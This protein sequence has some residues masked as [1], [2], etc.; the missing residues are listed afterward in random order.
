MVAR[1]FLSFLTVLRDV[2][3][4]CLEGEFLKDETYKIVYIHMQI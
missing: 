3:H 2:D 4:E 1:S